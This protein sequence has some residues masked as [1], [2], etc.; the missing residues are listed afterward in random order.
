[1]YAKQHLATI[2][3]HMKHS[4]LFLY[5]RNVYNSSKENKEAGGCSDQQ[6]HLL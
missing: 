3:F 1:M 2:L 4:F 6:N 5:L